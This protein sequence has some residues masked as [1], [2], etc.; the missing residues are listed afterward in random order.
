MGASGALRGSPGSPPLPRTPW[1]SPGLSGALRGS[2]RTGYPDSRGLSR[3]M[4]GPS[5]LSR[6]LRSC[7][8]IS[9]ALRRSPQLRALTGPRSS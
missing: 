4:H 8:V 5:L 3:L 6:A 1:G 7:E 9:E 2:P